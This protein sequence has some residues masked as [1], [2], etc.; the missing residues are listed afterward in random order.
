MKDLALKRLLRSLLVMFGVS[1]LTFLLTHLTGDPAALMLPLDA[2]PEQ[3]A[4]LRAE[5]GYDAPLWQQYLRFLQQAIGGDFG[6]SLRHKQAALPLILERMPATLELAGTALITS[7]LLAIPLGVLAACRRNSWL[8][9]ASSLLAILG[10]SLPAFCWGLMLQLVFGLLLPI[11]PITGRGT[12]AN[13]ILP[14]LTLGL[15]STA[16]TMRLLK[17]SLLEV[18]Q[19]DYVR[20]A[21]AKGLPNWL[22]IGKHALRNALLPVVTVIGLQ[23]GTLI[24]GAVIVESIFAWPGV[25][26]LLVQAIS[27]RDLPLVQAGVFV[28]AVGIVTINLCTDLLYTWLDPRIRL[29]G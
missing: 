13:L 2:T 19:Q 22:V 7:L 6:L 12:P 15:G 28:L 8:D 4:I 27:N 26:R 3:A 25:G 10:Q 20:T 24:G 17:S 9:H 21:R 16:S 1:L 5:L 29:R 18:L 23:M 14:A 11:L